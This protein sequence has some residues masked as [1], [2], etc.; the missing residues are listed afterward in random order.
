MKKYFVLFVCF[1]VLFGATGIYLEVYIKVVSIYWLVGKWVCFGTLLLGGFIALIKRKK[2]PDLYPLVMLPIWTILL[3][4][5]FYRDITEYKRNACQDK[6]GQEFNARRRSLGIPEIPANWH[7]D[8]RW[9]RYVDWKG[10]NG[11]TGHADKAVGVDSTCTLEFEQDD[12]DLKPLKDK[13]RDVTISTHYAKGNDSIFFSY[14]DGDSSH[15]ISRHK[16]DSIFA[17]E[18]IRKDY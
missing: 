14:Y 10:K 7:V 9:D 13:R 6:F 2:K 17:V 1:M 16:A 5:Q 11:V 12:Y 3:G 18:K 4:F 8:D 15:V